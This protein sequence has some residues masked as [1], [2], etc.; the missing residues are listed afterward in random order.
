[1]FTRESYLVQ[2]QEAEQKA[3][4]AIEDCLGTFFSAQAMGI[5][6]DSWDDSCG[7]MMGPPR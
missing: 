6:L 1:M 4:Q 2:E 5:M 7:L 3:M